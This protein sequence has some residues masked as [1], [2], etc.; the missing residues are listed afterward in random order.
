MSDSQFFFGALSQYSSA[1]RKVTDEKITSCLRVTRK[2]LQSYLRM[3]E[4]GITLNEEYLFWYKGKVKTLYESSA[5]V[6]FREF[7]ETRLLQAMA[8]NFE[9]YEYTLDFM[10]EVRAYFQGLYLLPL[11]ALLFLD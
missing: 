2:R 8:R 11:R 4:L 7:G 10:A 9:E 5:K 3:E 1:H 6:A